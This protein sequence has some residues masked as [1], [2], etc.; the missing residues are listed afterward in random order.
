MP[1]QYDVFLSYAHADAEAVAP[2]VAALR[3]E[4]LSVWFDESDVADFESITRSIEQGLA[5][6]KALLAY[7]SETY[8][9]RRPCQWELTAAFL[10]AHRTGNPRRRVLVV[11]PEDGAAHIH[12]VELSDALFARAP[13]PG[14]EEGLADLAARVSGHLAGLA[15]ALGETQPLTPPRWLP[16]QRTGS[17]RFVGRLPE[18]WALHS[19]L[20]ASGLGLITGART[21]VAQ[22]RG[23]GG[24]GK[25]LLAEE[26]ALRFGAA[27]P[28]G[29]FWVRAFGHGEGSLGAGQ[30]EAERE[31]QVRVLAQRLGIPVADLS[32]DE[33]EGALA[34]HLAEGDEEPRPCLWVVDDLASG[35][36]GEVRRWLAPHPVATTLVTTRSREYDAL[37]RHT[38]L[39][40]LSPEEALELLTKRR[41]P[42]GGEEREAAAAI[43]RELGFHPLA[44]DV[45]GA[46]L[47]Y[48]SY[49]RFLTALREPSEDRLERLTARLR[50]ALPNGHERSI[51]RTLSDSIEQLGEE[52]LD[53][54][55][56]AAL[57]AAAP[58]SAQLVA[59]VFATADGLTEDRA[60][61]RQSEALDQVESLSLADEVGDLRWSVHAL[62]VRTSPL[63]GAPRTR[64]WNRRFWR[65]V[66][67]KLANPESD[68]LKPVSSAAVRTR[69]SRPACATSSRRARAPRAAR[70]V[71][72]DYVALVDYLAIAAE[73]TG[74]DSG[75]LRHGCPRS[76]FLSVRASH[77][78]YSLGV[79]PQPSTR[80]R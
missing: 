57:V 16:E 63:S 38:D 34:R 68:A 69:S 29:V 49:E 53:F 40:V 64:T 76:A 22:L 1:E 3:G 72:V 44:L 51:A 43:A 55:R 78:W 48:R 37:G 60:E 80:R 77:E 46:A 75:F 61:D 31:R 18:L 21:A 45:A 9:V 52:G 28:G 50:D 47:R 67:F 27:Y 33:V 11:N 66:P 35:L 10:A 62:V 79:Q 54:L 26:Y 13:G 36:D 41:G 74:V 6:S 58:L 25:S 4:G 14:D 65:P 59:A 20:Q 23:L 70:Q 2:L 42:A 39:A 71:S 15:G 5:Q 19:D 56:L 24:V 17:G 73:V 30:R 8:P 7:Y 32:P 12:P